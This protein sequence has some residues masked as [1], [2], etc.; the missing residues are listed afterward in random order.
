MRRLQPHTLFL[1]AL[2]VALLFP[3]P[4]GA[5]LDPPPAAQ[6]QDDFDSLANQA[7]AARDAGKTDDAIL[8]YARALK[9]QP[10]WD[11]GLWYLGVL[12]YDQSHY[13]DAMPPLRRLL[14]LHSEIGA[15]WAFLGLC[16][17]ETQ[18]DKNS[19]TALQKAQQLGFAE[20]PEVARVARYHLALLLNSIGEF[21][22]G[23][24]LLISEFGQAQFPDQVK[25]ALGMALLRVPLLPAQ[26]DPSKD[27]LLRAAGEAA[28]AV[29]KKN[30]DRAAF[31]LQQ[32]L[33][34]YPDT[35]YLHYAYGTALLSASKYDDAI[36][37]FREEAR[38]RPADALPHLRLAS[39]ALQQQHVADA[40]RSAQ[41]AVD[42]APD[43]SD[44]HEVL[45]QAL[46]LAGKPE[47]SAR[48]LDTAKSLASHPPEI[49]PSIARTYAPGLPA[50]SSTSP[51]KKEANHSAA[52]S[53]SFE[54]LAEHARVAMQ[55]GQADTAISYYQRGL[56]LQPDW[57][58][59][60]RSLGTV[61]YTNARY[62]EAA[63]ALQNAVALNP[64]HGEAWALLG[65]SEFE[66]KDYQNSLIHLERGRDLGFAGNP[67]AVRMALYHTAALLNMNGEF[68][69]AMD[70]LLPEAGRGAMADQISFALG[71]AL[72]RIP[73][74]PDQIEP[75]KEQ[76]VRAAGEAAVFLAQSKYAEAFP[77]FQ[78]LLKDNPST[79]YLHYAY[80]SA[81]ASLSQ[82]DE[83][84]AQLREETR[85]SP[86]SALPYLRLASMF[87]RMHRLDDALPEAQRA[88]ALAPESAEGH[89]LLGRTFLELGRIPDAVGELEK[90]AH[91]APDSPEAHFSLA[92]AYAK[93][94]RPQ[95]A[96]QE[97]ASFERLNTLVQQQK[98]VRSSQSLGASS[99][100]TGLSSAQSESGSTASPH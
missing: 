24:A 9:L 23:T 48:E 46:Q 19:L 99:N 60:W 27:A 14:Q 3:Q 8:L 96:E 16:E 33:K 86:G 89:Y 1:L 10:D 55:S 87:L 63:T 81:L 61:C 45:A 76:L 62:A 42:L 26:V 44:A 31:L 35:P 20:D 52:L 64:R 79:P 88:S 2:A 25:T 58:E 66:L 11:E 34:Q 80:G 32:M 5:V 17:F 37:Q 53:E 56:K 18:D 78:H 71:I 12:N 40:V 67:E 70:L 77:V 15:A 22:K 73:T 39:I 6:S 21:E 97:R 90:A 57:E 54:Q 43:S 94:A 69:K 13:S 82:F 36:T 85:V 93:A 49:D 68:D 30:F 59:G 100:Q 51:E 41:H 91:L 83:A 84:A 4:A 50:I 74:L 98:D 65:L 29:A 72:L 38:L 75:S 28:A 47:Q 95:D 7:A 92:R